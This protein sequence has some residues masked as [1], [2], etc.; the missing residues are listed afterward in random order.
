MSISARNVYEGVVSALNAGPVS[1]EVEITTA[2]GD[3]LVATI[4]QASV[5][6]L[7]LKPGKAVVA[8][9]KASNVMVMTAGSGLKL[10]ARN[11]LSGTVQ[12]LLQGPVSADVIIALPGGA[13]VFASVTREATEELGLKEGSPVTAV[14]KASSV[15]V[16][17]KD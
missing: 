15:I 9:I 3:K 5:Q 12:K 16:G 10:S 13:E 4:T 6:T 8:V 2:G 1:A 17:V 11:C 7:G 14:I